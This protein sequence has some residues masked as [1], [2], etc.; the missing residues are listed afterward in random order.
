[1]QLHGNPHGREEPPVVPFGIRERL[2]SLPVPLDRRKMS[3][4]ETFR[5]G[6]P[7]PRNDDHITL[8]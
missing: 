1:M 7:L 2:P 3:R 6:F 8:A 4:V 5:K